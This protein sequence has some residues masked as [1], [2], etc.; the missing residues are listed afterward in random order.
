MKIM[1][2]PPIDIKGDISRRTCT[3]C[4]TQARI[5]YD[6]GGTPFTLCFECLVKMETGTRIVLETLLSEQAH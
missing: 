6:I 2:I 3:E 1:A 4:G 5:E